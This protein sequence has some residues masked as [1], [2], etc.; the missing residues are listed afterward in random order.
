LAPF[1][2]A[3]LVFAA[4]DVVLRFGDAA[5]LFAEP[6]LADCVRDADFC[7]LVLRE[8]LAVDLLLL[9]VD[10]LVVAISSSQLSD[11]KILRFVPA[12]E[13]F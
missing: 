10:R 11:P 7:V 13:R 9:P 3:R 1:V 2:D 8:R 12:A 5:L 4:A 6:A